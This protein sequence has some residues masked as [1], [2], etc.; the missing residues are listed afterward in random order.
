MVGTQQLRRPEL[1]ARLAG[2]LDTG[3]L[4]LVAPAGYGKTIALSAALE[5]R[6]GAIAWVRCDPSDTDPGRF[7]RRTLAALGEAAPGSGRPARG[8]RGRRSAPVDAR[9]RARDLAAELDRLVL[10][11]LT[12]AF[13]DAEHLERRV[14]GDRRR[15][16][17]RV[18]TRTCAWRSAAGARCPRRSLAC[19]P[20]AG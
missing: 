12:I 14:G 15:A 6:G 1:A 2:A 19:G 7:L 16:P 11:P 5:A 20:P 17:G 10:D 18:A 9:A 8:A 4:L 3:G 13:D